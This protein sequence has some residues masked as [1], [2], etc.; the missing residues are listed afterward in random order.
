[1]FFGGFLWGG[2]LEKSAKLVS[3]SDNGCQLAAKRRLT[4]NMSWAECID[5]TSMRVWSKA[6]SGKVPTIT[7]SAK[8]IYL[9]NAMY[10]EMV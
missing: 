8:L 4:K 5:Q 7:R 2:I 1:M 10:T 9:P 6:Q 3:L